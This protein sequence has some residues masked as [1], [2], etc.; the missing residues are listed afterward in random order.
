MPRLSRSSNCSSSAEELTGEPRSN[1]MDGL[2]CPSLSVT[3]GESEYR[4]QET[5]PRWP[6]CCDLAI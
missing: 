3:S 6:D 5:Y 2:R 1:E 4:P